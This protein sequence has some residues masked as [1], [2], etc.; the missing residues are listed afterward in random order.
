MWCLTVRRLVL[1]MAALVLTSML[2]LSVQGDTQ[3]AQMEDVLL[4][5]IEIKATMLLDGTTTLN[6]RARAINQGST[7]VTNVSFRIDSLNVAILDSLVDSELTSATSILQSRYT[8]VVVSLPSPLEENESAWVE[9]TLKAS[10]FQTEPHTLLDPSVSY[11]DFNLY[12][13]PMSE[14]ANFTFT[15]VLPQDAVLSR[16]SVV[17]LFPAADSNYTD[18]ASMAFIWFYDSIQAGQERAFIVKFQYLNSSS[19]FIGSF[20]LEAIGIAILGLIGGSAITLGGP[21]IYH[22]IKRIGSVKFVGVTSEEEEVL[23]VIRR[24]GGSCPQKDLYTEFNMSQ[25]K[26]SLILNNLEERGLVRRFKDGRE[27]VVHIM[28]D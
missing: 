24:K 16:E 10:D 5:P 9:L 3:L 19:V 6:L 15:A 4:D 18:G 14:Y 7:S 20:L 21:R 8:E 17:P 2:F 27:N 23:D 26:V 22:R 12:V 28:E 25:A 11:V 1:A 13:R